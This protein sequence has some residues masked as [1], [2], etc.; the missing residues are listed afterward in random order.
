MGNFGLLTHFSIP[1]AND[2]DEDATASTVN[3]DK[4]RTHLMVRKEKDWKMSDLED[5][6]AEKERGAIKFTRFGVEKSGIAIEPKVS[7]ADLPHK[8]ISGLLSDGQ[9]MITR[10]SAVKRK[11]INIFIQELKVNCR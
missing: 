3:P 8:T 11:N 4:T 1:G 6:G 5:S 2:G 10:G 7:T 9:L